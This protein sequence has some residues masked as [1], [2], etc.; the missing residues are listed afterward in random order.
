MYKPATSDVCY[1]CQQS[2]QIQ[3]VGYSLIVDCGTCGAY[4]METIVTTVRLPD[5]GSLIDY[6]KKERAS[7]KVR[8]YIF[9][10]L[11]RR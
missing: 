10:E 2:A 3:D 1:L 11:I 9:R 7:G 8:P 5:P 4:E 6:L